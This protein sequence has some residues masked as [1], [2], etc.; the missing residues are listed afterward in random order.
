M[1]HCRLLYEAREAK[2]EDAGTFESRL[3][4]KQRA[5]VQNRGGSSM[6]APKAAYVERRLR[7][8][9]VDC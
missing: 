3:A 2:M 6:L 7:R 9:T 1:L 5:R 4:L 8:L